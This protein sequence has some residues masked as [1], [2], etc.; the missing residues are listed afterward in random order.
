MQV[1]R[2]SRIPTGY[3]ANEVRLCIQP[4]QNAGHQNVGQVHDPDN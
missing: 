2:Q 4:L 1:T 3:R